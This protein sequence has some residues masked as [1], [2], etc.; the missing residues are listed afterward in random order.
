MKKTDHLYEH[1]ERDERVE[2]MKGEMLFEIGTEE[3][4]SG[5]LKDG[6]GEMARLAG[7]IFAENRIRVS[8]GFQTMGTPRRLVLV[9]SGIADH[10]DDAMDEILGPPA[11]VS[12]D[13]DGRPTR[14]ATG[15]AER[16]GIDI[17]QVE[18]KKT[19]KGE[20]LHLSKRTKG[21]P[22]KDV[23]VEVLP[24]LISSIPWPKVMRWG[25][26]GFSFVRP[27]H[28]ILAVL[29]GEI[30]PFEVAGI[31][32]SNRSR[33]HRFM[34]PQDFEVTGLE[35]YTRELEG[36]YVVVDHEKREAMVKEEVKE[37]SSGMCGAVL[38]DAD[39]LGTV[40][41]LVEFPSV[42]CGSIDPVFLSIPAPV[43]ITAMRK[44]QKY[45]AVHGRDGSLQPAFIAVNNTVVKDR[46]VVIK[47]HERVLRARLS[48]AQFFVREDQKHPLMDRLDD[49]KGVIFQAGLG[50]SLEKVNRFR[51]LALFIAKE[52]C[53]ERSKDVGVICS[54][55]KCDL[56]T[57]I[58]SEFPELQGVMGREYAI[59]EG[60]STDISD[61]IMEHYLPLRA[62]DDIP[63]SVLGAVVGIAD[64]IDT[65]S[66]FFALHL[67]PTGSAD[68]FALRRHAIAVLRIL[69]GMGWE[70]SLAEIINK[71]LEILGGQVSFETEKVFK[72]I[73]AFLKDRFKYLMQRRGNGTDIIEAVTGAGFDRIPDLLRRMEGLRKFMEEGSEVSSLVRSS[74][75]VS[76]IIRKEPMEGEIAEALFTAPSEARLWDALRS[77]EKK[78]ADSLDSGAYEKAFYA[79]SELREPV[80]GFFGEVEVLTKDN[81]AIRKNR[82]ALLRRA[83][84]LFMSLADLSKLPG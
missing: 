43:L 83:D 32:S 30:L 6:L 23:L 51:E 66:G 63:K 7:K 71:A 37:I 45:F 40:A 61:A 18:V 81:A 79:M 44:H 25:A 27:I 52:V 53:P 10:Q 46:A 24:V 12:F 74:K 65:I 48:D 29:D 72:G 41:N 64:R 77:V 13:K 33:G 14:A 20:Y 5:Y 84:S 47:G 54:L 35:Q 76:N 8:G 31:K 80:D 57:Q 4:P 11:K 16:H 21:R 26:V 59:R 39:L 68:P 34:A 36:R 17:S 19:P 60:Y 9:G 28:W 55:C 50:T 73:G 75:R 15:F 58:V 22:T 78:V 67:E 49:L 82:V 69:E 42:V 56:T 1:L 2:A 70:I 3:I 38:E 62:G